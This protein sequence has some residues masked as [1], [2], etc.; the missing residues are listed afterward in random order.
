MA[1]SF[2]NFNALL[3]FVLPYCSLS[4]V[5]FCF[6]KSSLSKCFTKSRLYSASFLIDSERFCFKP[7]LYMKKESG[8]ESGPTLYFAPLF[9]ASFST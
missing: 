6:S 5:I 2:K 8:L 3:W 4:I 7:Q 9:H 1:F